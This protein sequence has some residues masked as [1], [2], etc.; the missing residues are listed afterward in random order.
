MSADSMTDS[1]NPT[2]R[3]REVSAEDLQRLA[4]GGHLY[5]VVD[6]CS[7]P[8]VPRK[9]LELGDDRAISLYRETPEQDFWDV[10]PYLLKVDTGVLEWLRANASK[11]GWGI[12][13][14]SKADLAT[15]RHHLRHFLK[16]QA[17]DGRVWFFRF[18]DPRV[19]KPFLPACL[20]DELRTFFGPVLA[21]GVADP[22]IETAKF[23]QEAKPNNTEPDPVVRQKYSF[24]FKL[25]DAHLEALKPQAEAA[26]AAE[27]IEF[28]KSVS[29]SSV[30]GLPPAVLQK[31]VVQGLSRAR[32]YGFK[33]TS[34]LAAFVAIMFDVAPNF[35]QQ[36]GI[37]AVL[38]DRTLPPDLRIDA[39]MGRTAA[40][41]WEDALAVSNPTAWEPNLTGSE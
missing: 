40:Q 15:L 34:S 7:V 27:I 12:F 13:V 39:L 25:R 41:D 36:P 11:E 5:A 17:P 35:D 38:S 19:L 8:M 18:Y 33:R 28:L 6:A 1:E 32:R 37:R 9:V 20:G 26:F 16:V 22:G 24:M 10:A 14:A 29:S 23:F 30:G 31:R 2:V 3:E 21:C 4:S